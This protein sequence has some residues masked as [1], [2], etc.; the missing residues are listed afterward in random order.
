MKRKNNGNYVRMLT[1]ALGTTAFPK[2]VFN[3]KFDHNNYSK[4]F[5]MFENFLMIDD[6]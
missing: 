1:T 5:I 2:N 3:K 4:F 6:E